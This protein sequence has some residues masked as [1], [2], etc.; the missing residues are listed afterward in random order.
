MIR[1]PVEEFI[2]RSGRELLFYVLYGFFPAVATG[3]SQKVSAA[4]PLAYWANRANPGCVR[5]QAE[6][7]RRCR[8]RRTSGSRIV[9]D[10]PPAL[11]KVRF[12][13][14]RITRVR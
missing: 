14:V 12:A 13:T 9:H 1:S 11:P 7:A 3:T 6:G 10:V 8:H 4:I 5:I 2:P